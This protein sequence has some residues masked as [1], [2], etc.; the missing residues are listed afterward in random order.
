MDREYKKAAHDL[1]PAELDKA[2]FM[3]ALLN[4]ALSH[5][6]EIRAQ[7]AAEFQVVPEAETE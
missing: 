3:E 7:L 2:D 6:D 5:L 1:Y 4:F